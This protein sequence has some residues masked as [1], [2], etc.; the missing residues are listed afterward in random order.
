MNRIINKRNVLIYL[1]AVSFGN[2]VNDAWENLNEFHKVDKNRDFKDK[3][4][5]SFSGF[6]KGSLQGLCVGLFTPIFIPSLCI[7]TIHSIFNQ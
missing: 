4:D 2:G 5:I 3:F 1:G 6:F 7:S